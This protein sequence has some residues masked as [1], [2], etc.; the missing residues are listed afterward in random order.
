[1]SKVRTLK[2]RVKN[3]RA[4]CQKSIFMP[5]WDAPNRGHWGSRYIYTSITIRRS[6]KGFST[7]L[8]AD[9]IRQP[10]DES[11]PRIFGDSCR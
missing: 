9:L 5:H 7:E 3:M 2:K 8:A 11:L 10:S 4:T 1:M 6:L